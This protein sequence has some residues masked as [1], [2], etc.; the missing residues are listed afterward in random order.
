MK[1]ILPIIYMLTLIVI[2]AIKSMTHKYIYF[3]DTVIILIGHLVIITVMYIFEYSYY[4]LFIKSKPEAV[5]SIRSLLNFTSFA[6]IMW[7]SYII[8]GIQVII[9]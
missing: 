2:A 7:F 6:I 5:Q 3:S 9:D 4:K 8:I 1:K